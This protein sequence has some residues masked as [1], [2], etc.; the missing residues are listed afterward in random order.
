MGILTKRSLK[1]GYCISYFLKL[2]RQLSQVNIKYTVGASIFA[3][4]ASIDVIM[5]QL[6]RIITIHWIG[7]LLRVYS[8]PPQPDFGILFDVDGVLARGTNPLEPAVKALKLLQDEEGN[9]KVP[10]AFVTNACNRSE[11]KARQISKWFNVQVGVIGHCQPLLINLWLDLFI[12]L[13]ICFFSWKILHL[14][15][16]IFK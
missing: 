9:L 12:P 13:K 3:L 1:M 11:D 2:S 14:F 7:C 15:P 6:Y 16:F 10:V 8:F 5:W 4:L